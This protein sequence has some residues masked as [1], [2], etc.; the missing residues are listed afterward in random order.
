Y[1]VT[2]SDNELLQGVEALKTAR[3]LYPTD[4]KIPY[5]LALYYSTLYDS[6]KNNLDRQ[7]WQRLSLSEID[8]TINLKSNYREAY[9]FKGQ[10]LKKYGQINEAKKVFDYILK[11]FDSNDSEVI[12]ELKSL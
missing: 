6:T 12:N 11:N 7:N 10:L 3:K 9:L 4:P 8:K 1:Q 2:G 5:S